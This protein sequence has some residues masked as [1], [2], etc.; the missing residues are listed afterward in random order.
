MWEIAGLLVTAIVVY[1]F[2]NGRRNVDPMNRKCAA[3]ICEYLVSTAKPDPVAVREIFLR[4]ARYQKQANHVVSMVPA[5]LI[6]GGVP[7][8]VAMSFVPG[9]RMV[10]QTIPA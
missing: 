5:L 1:L 10:I 8:D 2:I 4:N 9:L 6:N 7:K 3:E